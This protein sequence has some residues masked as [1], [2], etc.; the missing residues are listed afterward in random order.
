MIYVQPCR[1]H[2]SDTEVRRQH[3]AT[4][5]LIHCEPQ[6]SHSGHQT[7]MAGA[8]TYWAVYLSSLLSWP[9]GCDRSPWAWLHFPSIFPC[10][11][12]LLLENGR[13]MF[14][15]TFFFSFLCIRC[16]CKHMHWR[17]E[18]TVTQVSP[19]MSFYIILWDSLSLNLELI[20]SLDSWSK[21]QEPTC[22]RPWP[23]TG[24]QVYFVVPGSYRGVGDRTQVLRS[25]W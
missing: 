24:P 7:C 1:C 9:S 25:A 6:G 15:H 14:L 18:D 11:C 12:R 10:A 13:E 20:N 23:C 16:S 21:V 19:F 2:N 22:L 3:L 4:C 8:L 17:P 5:F